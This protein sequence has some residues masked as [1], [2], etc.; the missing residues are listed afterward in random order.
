MG[1]PAIPPSA[2]LRAIRDEDGEI[3]GVPGK[4]GRTDPLGLKVR[5]NG[6]FVLMLGA[7]HANAQNWGVDGTNTLT[8][9]GKGYMQMLLDGGVQPYLAITT[10]PNWGHAPGQAQAM[11]YA[12]AR[13]LQKRGVEMLS[14]SHQHI[15][16]WSRMNTGIFIGY[17][18]AN[19]TATV[20]ISSTQVILTAGA[21]SL[22]ITRADYTSLSQ[23]CAAVTAFNGGVWQAYM[24]DDSALT[25]NELLTNLLPISGARN[26]KGTPSGDNRYFCCGGGLIIWSDGPSPSQATVSQIQEHVKV[27][28]RSNG[29]IR[30]SIDGITWNYT[31]TNAVATDTFAELVTALNT[32]LNSKGVYF[33]I[34]DNGWSVDNTQLNYM[35]G[36]E[37]C[38]GM[39]FYKDRVVSPGNLARFPT[40]IEIGLT[41]DYM[42]RRQVDKSYDLA[43]ANG[44][45]FKGFAEPGNQ[46]WHKRTRGYGRCKVWRGTL[47]SR[48][49]TQPVTY[50]L[51]ALGSPYMVRSS[52]IVSGGY[53]TPAHMVALVEAMADSPGHACCLLWHQL[54]TLGGTAGYELG[55]LTTEQDQTATNVAA[56]LAALKPHLASGKIIT[57]RMSDAA[58]AIGTGGEPANYLFNAGFKNSGTAIAL[59][60]VNNSSTIPGWLLSVANTAGTQVSIDADGYFV[61]N[62]PSSVCDVSIKQS[63]VVPLH[64]HREYEFGFEIHEAVVTGGD[65]AWM[66]ISRTQGRPLNGNNLDTNM[67]TVTALAQAGQDPGTA[68]GTTGVCGVHARFS[69]SIPTTGFDAARIVASPAATPY[70][71]VTGTNDTLTFVVNGISGGAALTLAPSA[72]KTA[73]QVADEINAYFKT[74]SVFSTYPEF[75]DIAKAKRGQRAAAV[76][77]LG[78]KQN[79]YKI[80]VAGTAL[81]T[82]F[83]SSNMDGTGFTSDGWSGADMDSSNYALA[84]SVQIKIQGVMRWRSPYFKPSEMM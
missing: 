53:D 5:P 36:D 66:N 76:V 68:N 33:A 9:T 64:S 42:F 17:T 47:Y 35:R 45:N 10:S 3:L 34:S 72:A 24:R 49:N 65:G 82:V 63:I 59:G 38:G 75:Q 28:V 40:I 67:S 41:Q 46:F 62:S 25:G 15:Q 1:I 57:A 51:K 37:M 6:K 22:T 71:V 74:D 70:N 13:T 29:Y 58:D 21:D 77:I 18:G 60:T 54:N 50:P 43:A 83:G 12:Q 7:D 84:V 26:T 30:T 80:N 39:T 20:A 48:L 52:C 78:E 44:I 69:P 23:F 2:G 31:N 32:A 56:F 19:A 8:A 27:T 16:N 55:N 14:H 79:V 11:T 81:A 61:I 4:N 73:I